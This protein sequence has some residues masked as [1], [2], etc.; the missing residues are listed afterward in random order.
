LIAELFCYI[1]YVIMTIIAAV[2]KKKMKNSNIN[3]D[4]I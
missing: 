2:T 1:V 4:L 3:H